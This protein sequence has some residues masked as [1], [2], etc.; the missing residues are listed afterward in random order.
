MGRRWQVRLL[1]LVLSC[2]VAGQSTVIL[3]LIPVNTPLTDTLFLAASFNDWSPSDPAY[4]FRR[5]D[6]RWQLD[7]PHAPPSFAFKVTRGSWRKV[8]ADQF[9]QQGPDR[10]FSP[11]GND[12]MRI[13]VKSW[14]DLPLVSGKGQVKIIVADWPDNT[15]KD[16][17]LYLVGS[18]NQWKTADDRYRLQRASEDTWEVYMP[19]ISDTTFY[20][21]TRGNWATVEGR[22]N[23]QARTNRQYI[24]SSSSSDPVRV[25]IE[26]WEDLAGH[27][28][29]PYTFF[30]LL[31]AAQGVLFLLGI[32]TIR[33]GN[34]VANRMLSILILIIT[35]ALMGRVSTYD[36]DLFNRF[37]HLL[38]LPDIVYFLYGPLFFLYIQRLL[39]L[40]AKQGGYG[41]RQWLHFLPF[42]VQL[43]VY[44]PLLLMPQQAFIDAVVDKELKTFFAW[45]ALAAFFFNAVYWWWSR[46]FVRSYLSTSG[47]Q[48]AF[49]SNVEFLRAAFWTQF[50]AILL[51]GAACLW[52]LLGRL[53]GTDVAF[54]TENLVDAVWITLS[55]TAF[56]LGFYSVKKPEIFRLPSE[57]DMGQG[58]DA[59]T[60]SSLP[61]TD[62]AMKEELVHLRK[63]VAG[64]M[65]KDKPYRNPGLTLEELAQLVGT[66]RH[67]LSRAINEGI[68][69]NFNDF[70]NS[71]RVKEFK[72]LALDEGHRHHTLLAVAYIVGF[73]SKSAFNRSFKK[74]ENCTPREY[75]QQHQPS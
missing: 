33:D 67:L 4:A 1:F 71:Y 22:P 2:P 72:A 63:Q 34:K 60:E 10:E 28:L 43:I 47:Q 45:T 65:S 52:W 26:S 13:A 68:G 73:N 29:G 6:G 66:N 54:W 62:E 59:P 23:G 8:E 20:K 32:Q 50:G 11:D 31:A 24:L 53:T 27:P 64:I 18:F 7:L 58:E 57:L 16:A 17:A 41:N 9:G 56:L 5:V 12:T 39:R 46:K 49:H 61:S 14:E 35:I 36:R 69:V 75:V 55:I 21:F 48:H 37:P 25:S 42:A 38:L 30:L 74:L 15:P 70:V 44:I 40:P 19:L 51:L 3:D